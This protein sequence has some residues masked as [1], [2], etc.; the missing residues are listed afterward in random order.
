MANIYDKI[1]KIQSV[2]RKILFKK[3]L[4]KLRHKKKEKESKIFKM[5][6]AFVKICW[7]KNFLFF[8]KK[9]KSK[10]LQ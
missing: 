1:F 4:E 8:K 9:I 2:F 5:I 10:I 7:L 6:H 3:E